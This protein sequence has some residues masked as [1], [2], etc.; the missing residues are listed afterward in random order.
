MRVGP[1]RFTPPGARA[2]RLLPLAACLGLACVIMCAC[3]ADAR[4]QISGQSLPGR[5][6]NVEG[7]V[8]LPDDRPA[9][10]VR[11]R[12]SGRGAINRETYT[13]DNGRFEFPDLPGGIYALTAVSLTEPS[14][15]AAAEADTSRTAVGRLTVNMSLRASS[16][17]ADRP[18]PGVISAA[19][20]G[21]V[22]PS[23]AQ[24]AYRR[25]L[26]LKG[27]GRPDEALASFGRA[28]ELFPDYFQALSERGDLRVA[29]RELA[30]AEADFERALKANARYAPALRGA[31]YCKL[32]GRDFARAA[33]Y[34]ERA[35][36]AEP[37]NVSTN[38]LLGI[39]Y[40]E[41]DRR[42]AARQSLLKALKLGGERALRAHI[43]LAKL[44]AREG[45][46]RQAADELRLYLDAVV[47]DADYDELRRTEAKWRAMAKEK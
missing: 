45:R 4:G 8:T 44:Y 14:L 37:S 16:A 35:A 24:K 9:A 1:A 13:N 38:L 11:V 28:V 40:L 21:Q 32:E 42:D 34:L 41:L 19:E 39:A 46:Y 25:G 20:A 6:F 22:V 47:L 2:P 7:R 31:G 30:E 43:H 26:K 27:D 17:A 33:E 10:R 29:R 23:A 5:L 3:R 36:A 15:A 12:L 18:P